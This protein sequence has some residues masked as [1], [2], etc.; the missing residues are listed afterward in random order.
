MMASGLTAICGRSRYKNTKSL[1][2]DEK[3]NRYIVGP[4][5][6]YDPQILSE[7]TR[8]LDI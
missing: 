5:V 4:G 3:V 1:P 2:A 8:R 7:P 6:F